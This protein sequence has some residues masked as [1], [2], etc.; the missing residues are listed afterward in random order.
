MLHTFITRISHMH[1]GKERLIFTVCVIHA[2]Q[3]PA[4]RAGT[5][6]DPLPTCMQFL[7][8]P[9]STDTSSPCNLDC[10]GMRYARASVTW[11]I[12]TSTSL[13]QYALYVHQSPALWKRALD[14]FFSMR[15]TRV[16]V[17]WTMETSSHC[18]S[19]SYTRVSVTWTMETS[20]H[21]EL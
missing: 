13:S 9:A 15:Y 19:V 21:C 12:V 6:S 14:L 18:Y 7:M 17:T 5:D 10:C 11:S 16:S 4:L 3:S 8:L 20:S 1:Y 2:H